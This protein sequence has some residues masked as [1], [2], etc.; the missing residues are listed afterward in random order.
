MKQLEAHGEAGHLNVITRDQDSVVTGY[1]KH[2][3]VVCFL[4]KGD[5]FYARVDMLPV[6]LPFPTETQIRE[7]AKKD[8]SIRGRWQLAKTEPW[9]YGGVERFDCMFRRTR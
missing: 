2:A 3:R 9:Q 7:V 4:P 5:E 8:Q 6:G 1:G